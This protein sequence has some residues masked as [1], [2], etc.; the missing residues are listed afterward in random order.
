MIDQPF[1]IVFQNNSYSPIQSRMI[2]KRSISNIR[3]PAQKDD[4]FYFEANQVIYLY[5]N[6]PHNRSHYPK[7]KCAR[8]YR[9]FF[10]FHLNNQI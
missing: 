9:V 4:D 6:C 2:D 8:C 5:A 1:G 7:N 10:Q 3:K